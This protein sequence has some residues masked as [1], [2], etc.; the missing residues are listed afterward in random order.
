MM[1]NALKV[2]IVDDNK[3]DFQ[4]YKDIL[5][6]EFNFQ[7]DYCASFDE[8]VVMIDK[9]KYDLIFL[10]YHFQHMS[11]LY[12][13]HNLN[14]LHINFNIPIIVLK[15][16]DHFDEIVHYMNIGVKV[17]L[18]KKIV[19]YLHLSKAIEEALSPHEKDNTK[20]E[21]NILIIDDSLDDIEFYTRS[22]KSVL[23]CKIKTCLS[24]E[25]G[26]EKIKNSK[27][28]LILLDY[29]LKT[30]NG[31]EFVEEINALQLELHGPIIALTGQGNEQIAVEF[32]RLGVTDYIPK[33]RISAEKLLRSVYSSF[34]KN[35]G[36]RIEKEKNADLFLFA[37]TVAHDLKSPLGRIKAYSN[38]LSKKNSDVS[39]KYLDNIC[40]D[41]NYA[42]EFLNTLLTYAELGR[43]NLEKEETDL[44]SVLDQTIH[45][46]EIDIQNKKASIKLPPLPN[47][48][49]HKIA[50]TELFQNLI[51]NSIKY[52]AQDPVI[53]ITS[54]INKNGVTIS[55]KDNGIGIPASMQEDAFKPFKRIDN[56]LDV[57]GVGLGLALCKT[58]V[59]QHNGMI[60]ISSVPSGGTIFTIIFPPYQKENKI[61]NI[62]A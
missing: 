56:G 48:Y 37:H 15:E 62:A 13:F 8:F 19:S 21:L 20:N 49:G 6:T 29:Y 43:S 59:A 34:E 54:A 36:K 4:L 55:I 5:K 16:K 26:L 10:D 17:I 50:L 40:N 12:F 38:L 22:L 42:I 46:L 24:A 52:C 27:Y 60:E 1:T 61:K 7:I 35:I 44:N 14:M 57:P 25:L 23:K 39:V 18:D 3:I 2:L 47:I 30:M 28:D 33:F 9:K 51:S 58:I 45:N 11:G 32:M 31:I 53:E 41:V